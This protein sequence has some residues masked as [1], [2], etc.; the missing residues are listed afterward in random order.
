MRELTCA[1]LTS[2]GY[3]FGPAKFSFVSERSG[4]VGA[5][6]AVRLTYLVLAPLCPL[7]VSGIAA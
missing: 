7:L 2:N 1:V 4:W 6:T 5:K 3:G